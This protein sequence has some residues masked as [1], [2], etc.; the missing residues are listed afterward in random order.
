MKDFHIFSHFRTPPRSATSLV[1]VVLCAVVI[2][3]GA[4]FFVWQ[5]FQFIRLSFEASEL[6]SRKEHLEEQI[7]PLQV[8]VEYLSRLERIDTL[9]RGRLGMR[10][11][12]NSQVMVMEDNE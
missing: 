3:F 12:R 4:V 6:R 2:T 11:P 7:E 8:E 9:A 10:P 1:L 5:R